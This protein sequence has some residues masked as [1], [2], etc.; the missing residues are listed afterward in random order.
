[1]QFEYLYTMQATGNIDIENI[2]DFAISVT[3]DM[4]KE[5]LMIVRTEYGICQIIQYGPLLID[6]DELPEN[7]NYNYQRMEYNEGKLVRMID[8]FINDPSKLATQ[9]TEINIDDATNKI[10]NMIDVV[11]RSTGE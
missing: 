7:V 2:G 11:C 9:V 10:V 1:M 3:N 4:C 5:W 6:F 8:K